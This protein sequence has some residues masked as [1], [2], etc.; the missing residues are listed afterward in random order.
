MR[1]LKGVTAA[2]PTQYIYLHT[3]FFAGK[4][5]QEMLIM[6]SIKHVRILNELTPVLNIV[7]TGQMEFSYRVFHV[8]EVEQ[9][10][11]D[12]SL[13]FYYATGAQNALFSKSGRDRKSVV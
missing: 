7:F 12:G 10:L 8:H 6:V 2:V 9:A 13:F 4:A 1:L 11:L 3:H 5:V